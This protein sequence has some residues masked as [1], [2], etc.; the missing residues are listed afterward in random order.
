MDS[1]R[2]QRYVDDFEKT[3]IDDKWER[4]TQYF[5]HNAEYCMPELS[6]VI[7]GRD[8]IFK[9]LKEAV[10][11][12]DRL[13][14]GCE[15]RTIV[16]PIV[17]NGEIYR[18]W[19]SRFS[20]RGAPDFVFEGQTVAE[21]DGD[22]IKRLRI[23][24]TAESLYIMRSWIELHGYLLRDRKIHRRAHLQMRSRAA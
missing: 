7:R 1:N 6:V 22:R 2:F 5:T 16:G 14:D 19:S 3:I 21:T 13:M 10:D 9:V 4:L 24:P 11:N 18:D 15:Y 20:L 12:F 23:K 8:Q 17:K